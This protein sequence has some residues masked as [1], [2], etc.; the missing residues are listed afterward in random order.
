MAYDEDL[1]DRIR[2]LVSAH[3][4]AEEKKMFGGLGFLLGGNMAVCAS[5]DGGLLVRT[6]GVGFE[7]LLRDEHV[8]PM[9]MAGR[10]SKTWL[11]V[12][13]EGVR[14]KRQL[15]RWVSRGVAT[16][17]ALPPKG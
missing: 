12:A 1:A 14:T 8:E 3:G 4:S 9:V 15:E 5:H 2:E 16:A 11:R 13:P 7:A 10:A 17:T 6:D